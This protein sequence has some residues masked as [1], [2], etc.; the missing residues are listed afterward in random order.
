M[1]HGNSNNRNNGNNGMMNRRSSNTSRP[2]RRRTSVQN[3]NN[4]MMNRRTSC[5]P[6]MHMMPNGQCMEGAY[7][8]APSNT[9]STGHMNERRAPFRINNA[10]DVNRMVGRPKRIVSNS[11]NISAGYGHMNNPSQLYTN[12]NTGNGGNPMPMSP[13]PPSCP[14]GQCCVP[15]HYVYG[16]VVGGVG[17]GGQT[18]VPPGCAPCGGGMG[19]HTR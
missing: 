15:G 7:H 10:R 1:Y 3:G 4:G 17:T 9:R 12:Q 5:P 2:M 13:C 18:W 19:R 14:P 11:N 8:G 6:G 16:E